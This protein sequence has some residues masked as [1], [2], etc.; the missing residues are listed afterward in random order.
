MNRTKGFIAEENDLEF[1]NGKALINLELE[2]V[3]LDD[4]DN[5]LEF[6]FEGYVSAYWRIY[7]DKMREE[8]IKSFTTQITQ[9]GNLLYVNASITDM[10]FEDQGPYYFEIGYNRTGYETP[11]RYGELRII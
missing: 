8:I 6:G 4:D 5:E 3:Y 9:N 7:N 11:L 1:Y 2:F 10:S